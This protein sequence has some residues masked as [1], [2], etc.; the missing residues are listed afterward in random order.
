MWQGMNQ[1]RFPRV[2]CQ[3]KVILRQ[4]GATRS[5]DST[6]E[7]IGMGG[8]CVFLDKGM[9]I[10]APVELNLNLGDGKSPLQAK[11]TIVWV[12]RRRDLKQGPSFDT[13]IEFSDLS[14]EDKARLEALIDKSEP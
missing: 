10:F 13:G 2:K 5:I 14:S 6:T 8:I 7:N 9:D 4:E 3:C 1:R 11:G 12:V